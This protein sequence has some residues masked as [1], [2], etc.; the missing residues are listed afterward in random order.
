MSDQ[1]QLSFSEPGEKKILFLN[2]YGL[3]TLYKK[4]TLRFLKVWTQTVAAPAITTLLFMAVFALALGADRAAMGFRFT[5]FLVP[6]LVMMAVIQNAYQNPSSSILIGKVQG[7][8]IDVL[9]PPLSPLELTL[10][11]VGGGITRGLIVG[12]TVL[13]AFSLVPFIT[14]HMTHPLVALYFF[15]TGSIMM[16]LVGALTGIWAQK[17]DHT[18]AIY[19]F[20]VMPLSLLSG[21]FYTIDRLTPA[22]QAVSKLNPFYYLIDGFRYGFLGKGDSDLMIGVLYTFGINCVLAYLVYLVFKTGWK[23]RP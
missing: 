6:G 9:M 18:A 7:N 8:I 1:R 4:E 3:W 22:F 23:L 12:L 16:S 15:V 19:N 2:S 13:F 10:G 11:Y 5:D 14:I 20:I 17:F 21:T